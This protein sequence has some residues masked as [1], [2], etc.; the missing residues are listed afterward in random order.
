MPAFISIDIHSAIV[1]SHQ[2]AKHFNVKSIRL[3]LTIQPAV[4]CMLCFNIDFQ[5]RQ[6]SDLGIGSIIHFTF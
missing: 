6:V 5:S 1:I 4:K 3:R 2:W